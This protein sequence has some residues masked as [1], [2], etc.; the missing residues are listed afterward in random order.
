MA[1]ITVERSHSYQGCNLPAIK[2]AQFR[3]ISQ[4][5]SGKHGANPGYALEQVVFLS[6][7]GTLPDAMTQV[8]INMSHLLLQPRDMSLDV[9]FDK[10][11]ASRVQA[12]SLCRKHLDQLT[13]AGEDGLQLLPLS[14]R[15][16]ARWGVHRSRK[17]SQHP[18]INGISLSQAPRG[19]S[20]I[21]HLARVDHYHWHTSHCQS[22]RQ[23]ILKASGSFQNYQRG[24]QLL[25]A[26]E[27]LGDPFIGVSKSP[28]LVTV[29][30][31][32]IQ[33]FLRHIDTYIDFLRSH[34]SPSPSVWPF[35][36]R[37]GL[38]WPRQLFGLFNNLGTTT[39]A[40][41]RSFKT[42]GITVCRALGY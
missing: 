17:M 29:V 26:R 12:V 15:Q 4:Q 11:A 19:P 40:G 1:A 33:R 32:H 31:S 7:D 3:E 21:P 9:R 5:G 2:Q 35:L 42:K 38:Y 34:W 13:P 28:S 18:S 6:P 20:K 36:A 39:L 30:D 22:S 41:P 10:P 37:Y 16:E 8:M 27:S 25:K 23:R 24:T 14:I